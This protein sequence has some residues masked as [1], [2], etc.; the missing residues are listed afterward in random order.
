MRPYKSFVLL[1]SLTFSRNRCKRSLC[2]PAMGGDG[3]AEKKKEKKVRVIYKCIKNECVYEVLFS[4][5]SLPAIVVSLYP[6]V[7]AYKALQN[8]FEILFYSL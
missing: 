3:G 4:S 1:F 6:A 2:F 5:H 7:C 8:S